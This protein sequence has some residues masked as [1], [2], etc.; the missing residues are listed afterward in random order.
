MTSIE[1][2]EAW[3][4]VVSRV[5]FLQYILLAILVLIALLAICF[6]IDV[7]LGWWKEYRG[8]RRALRGPR[9]RRVHF[10]D[11]EH[12]TDECEMGPLSHTYVTVV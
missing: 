5:D 3:S 9:P 6:V 8:R 10:G 1:Y 11:V 7:G 12:V 4:G 2:I